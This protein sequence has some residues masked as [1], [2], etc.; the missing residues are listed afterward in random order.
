MTA[1]AATSQKHSMSTITGHPFRRAR[2]DGLTIALHWITV[3]LVALLWTGGQTID[4]LGR[5]PAPTLRSVHIS[6][7]ITLALVLSARIAWRLAGGVRLSGEGEVLRHI[8]RAMHF[9]LYMLTVTTLSFGVTTAWLRG[10]SVFGLLA[11]PGGA[12]RAL[13]HTVRDWH[14]LAANT[15]LVLASLHAGAALLHHYVL[16]DGVLRRMLPL[17]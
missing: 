11:F 6:L 7:G 16:R 12:D 10:D 9:V 1:Q 13:A 5:G 17:A 14:A 15:I 4:A 3:L 8:A 2:Y